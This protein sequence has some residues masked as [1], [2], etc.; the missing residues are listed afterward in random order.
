MLYEPTNIIPSIITQ[1][2]TIASADPVSVQWQVNGTSPM[3]AFQIDVY[4]DN[5]DSTFVHS[6]GVITAY[7]ES[8]ANNLL[9]FYG[10]DRLGEYVPFT[11]TPTSTTW[12]NWGLTDGNNYKFVITQFFSAQVDTYSLNVQSSIP[13]KESRVKYFSYTKNGV[14]YYPTFTIY[15]PFN[16]ATGFNVY[17]CD[18][19]KTGWVTYGASDFTGAGGSVMSGVTCV[20]NTTEPEIGVDGVNAASDMGEGVLISSSGMGMNYYQQQFIVQNAPSAIITR[21]LPT[22]Q[23]DSFGTVSGSTVTVDTSVLDFSASYNQAQGDAVNSVRWQMFNTNDMS[24]PIDDTGIIYTPIL[25]YEYNGLF[26]GQSYVVSCTVTSINGQ[27]VTYSQQFNVDYEAQEYVGEVSVQYVCAED[28]AIVSWEPGMAI[29]GVVTPAEGSTIVDNTLELDRGATLTWS[30]QITEE[31]ETQDLNISAPWTAVWRGVSLPQTSTTLYGNFDS[32][33]PSGKVNTMVFSPDNEYL[34]IG[35]TFEGYGRVYKV[36]SSTSYTYVGDILKNGQPLDGA[37][38]SISVSATL[39]DLT[40]HIAV[41]GEFT[42]GAYISTFS[43]GVFSGTTEVDFGLTE[44]QSLG[45]I[46]AVAYNHQGTALCV[47]GYLTGGGGSGIA[48]LFEVSGL[49]LITRR[50]ITNDAPFYRVYCA[51]FSPDDAVLIIGGYYRWALSNDEKVAA[52]HIVYT[53]NGR[54]STVYYQDYGGLVTALY[55]TCYTLWFESNTRCWAGGSFGIVALTINTASTSRM[56]TSAAYVLS[57]ADA[58]CFSGSANG[59]CIATACEGGANMYLVCGNF[60]KLPDYTV[61]TGGFGYTPS[62]NC[63]SV[64]F[65]PTNSSFCLI[66]GSGGVQIVTFTYPS[67]TPIMT[68]NGG[69]ENEIVVGRD[70][71]SLYL[72]INDEIVQYA[73]LPYGAN[74]YGVFGYTVTVSPTRFCVYSYRLNSDNEETSSSAEIEYDIPQSNISEVQ[75]QGEQKCEYF[76]VVS[77]D[78]AVSNSDTDYESSAYKI[79]WTATGYDTQMLADFVYGVGAGT[80]TGG[81]NGYRIYRVEADGTELTEV[82]TL[83]A[84]RAIPSIRDFGIKSNTQYTYVLFVYDN[85]NNFMGQVTTQSIK[86]QFKKYSLLATEYSELDRCYHVVKEYLF[87]CSL[88]DE[89]LSNNS[90]KSYA[91]NFTPYPTVFRSTANYASGTLQALIGFVDKNTYRYWDDTA[92]MAELNGLSTTDYTLFLRDMKGH[93]WMVDVGTVQQTVKY[94]TREMQVT[95]SLPWTEI[96]NAEDVSIIQTP[97]DEGWNYDAQVLDVKLDVNMDT[98]ALEV[99]YPF[100]Y[101]GTAFYLVGVTPQGVVSAVQPLPATACSPTDGQLKAVIRHK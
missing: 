95:I 41:G 62:F 76:A 42:G 8:G 73:L 56:I 28:S 87:S 10:K 17:F 83:S 30:Q 79:S 72:Q 7:P 65:F 98:G 57:G 36:N 55:T 92:L 24:T 69:A 22:L 71:N 75:L 27:S 46:Y 63:Y 68:I 5:A 89:A 1:T 51:A 37:I 47:C 96:G 25:S 3:S 16:E 45:S 90:N 58:R 50:Y 23:I 32:S 21:A 74:N 49:T 4:L 54:I 99:V 12:A 29:P 66:G 61:A 39:S 91:Q 13:S 64:A 19:L 33:L 18:T 53:D 81:S 94:G 2:G 43:D 38:N 40:Y 20:L 31:G 48:A 52:F 14:T 97:E 35:G 86:C 44:G 67:Q 93:I 85:N 59:A 100:P 9:P 70:Y 84:D 80:S 101:N 82:V 88:T 78:R 60:S 77:G 11:Y 15:N 6:T 34:F 26:N